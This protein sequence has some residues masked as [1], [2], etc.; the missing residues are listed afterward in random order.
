MTFG[1]HKLF[2]MNQPE[3]TGQGGCALPWTQHAGDRWPPVTPTGT[4]SY[5]SQFQ[6][7]TSSKNSSISPTISRMVGVKFQDA[8][9]MSPVLEL[10]QGRMELLQGLV[11]L[12]LGAISELRASL[13]T[14]FSQ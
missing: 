12:V 3:V 7:M 8:A 2:S 5:W 13:I 11:D 1:K 6:D 4:A 14:S 10:E 9:G